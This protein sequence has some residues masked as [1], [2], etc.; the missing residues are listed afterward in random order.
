MWS[1]KGGGQGYSEVVGVGL[2]RQNLDLELLHGTL[3]PSSL[4]GKIARKRKKVFIA[5]EKTRPRLLATTY[6]MTH[7]S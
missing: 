3:R 1:A 6:P 5:V 7:Q 4:K 2:E